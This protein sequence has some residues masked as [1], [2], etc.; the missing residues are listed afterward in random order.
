MLLFANSNQ[1]QFHHAERHFHYK[2]PPPHVSYRLFVRASEREI[3]VYEKTRPVLW[4][5]GEMFV[6]KI[7]FKKTLR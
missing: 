1:T 3:Y 5:G 7:N 4:Y 6:T 2:S